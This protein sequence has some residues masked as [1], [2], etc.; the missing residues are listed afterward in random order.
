[1][2]Q[3]PLN[4]SYMKSAHLSMEFDHRE[5]VIERKLQLRTIEIN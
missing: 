2:G 4:V 3:Q 5:V 1:M